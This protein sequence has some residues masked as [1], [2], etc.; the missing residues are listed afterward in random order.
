MKIIFEQHIREQYMQKN[1]EKSKALDLAI[2][3]I[4]KHF[5]KG[6]VMKLGDAK[7]VKVDSI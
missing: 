3:Q 6:A 1:N 7:D 2:S 4:D 5:G